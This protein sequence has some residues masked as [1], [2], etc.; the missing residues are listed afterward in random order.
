MDTAHRDSIKNHDL[1][2]TIIFTIDMLSQIFIDDKSEE[3]MLSRVA[4][5]SQTIKISS[6]FFFDL[7]SVIPLR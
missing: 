4:E 3:L 6:R 5:G 7:C 1:G 2:Y